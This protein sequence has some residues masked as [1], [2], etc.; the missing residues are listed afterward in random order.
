MI[1]EYGLA[2][3][4]AI[5]WAADA[6]KALIPSKGLPGTLQDMSQRAHDYRLA[7]GV[8]YS[9]ISAEHLRGQE[10]L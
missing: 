9:Y 6:D 3:E 8:R 5:L 10:L 2:D 1:T 4:G 7:K